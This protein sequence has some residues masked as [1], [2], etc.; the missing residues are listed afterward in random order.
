[1]N[2]KDMNVTVM[3][4]SIKAA[5]KMGEQTSLGMPSVTIEIPNPYGGKVAYQGDWVD[6]PQETTDVTLIYTTSGLYNAHI[7]WAQPWS[8]TKDDMKKF[9]QERGIESTEEMDIEFFEEYFVYFASK[10]IASHLS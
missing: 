1:M 5:I 8:L 9:A 10:H 3:K 7:D 4:E 6:Q 2:I